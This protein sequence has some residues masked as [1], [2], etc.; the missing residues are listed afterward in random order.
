MT[1]SMTH[2]RTLQLAWAALLALVLPAIFWIAEGPISALIVAAWGWATILVFHL[3]RRRSEVIKILGN[4]GD[5]RVRT[6]HLKALAFAGFVLWAVLTVWWLVS[7]S[8]GE[9]NEAVGILA[10]TFGVSYIAA[11][12]FQSRRG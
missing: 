10:A 5:E 7:A 6:L 2:T 9:G 4:T 3:G 12:L 11:A 8:S 1:A